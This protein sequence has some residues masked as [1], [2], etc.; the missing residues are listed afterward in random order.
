MRK[1]P[2]NQIVIDPRHDDELR[3]WA[4]ELGVH[5]ESLRI[6]IFEVGPRVV[7]LR[8]YFDISEIIPFPIRDQTMQSRSA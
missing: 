3:Y 8:A 2:L 5:P 7:K 6:A 1:R 4:A